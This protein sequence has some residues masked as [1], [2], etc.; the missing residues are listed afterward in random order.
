MAAYRRIYDS[1]HCRLTAKNRDQLR[2]P[3]LGNQAWC[4]VTFLLKPEHY[5][6]R[7][8]ALS[9]ITD[10]LSGH[11]QRILLDGQFSA[12]SPVT[13][14]IPQ[15][16][17][18]SPFLI[19]VYINDLPSTVCST[20]WMFADDCLLYRTIKTVHDTNTLQSDLDSLQ[21]W[22]KDWLTEFNPSKCEVITFT[23]KVDQ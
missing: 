22:E 19:L 18:L 23:G 4:T 15:G 17:V 14:G 2:N 10:F 3:T 11:T 20:V 7:N 12:T 16:T 8:S 1:S 9:W 21:Q 6:I 13:S 5:G